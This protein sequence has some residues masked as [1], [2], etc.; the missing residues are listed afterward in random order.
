MPR[1]SA[2]NLLQVL[3]LLPLQ[4]QLTQLLSLLPLAVL[5]LLLLLAA[6]LL[7]L[8][9]LIVNPRLILLLLAVRCS[10]GHSA[11]VTDQHQHATHRAALPV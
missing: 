2:A 11:G 1:T 6:K 8:L 4:A 5:L 3:L 10:L 7:L 9:L